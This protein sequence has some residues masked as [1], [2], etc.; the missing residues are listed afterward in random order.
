[1]KNKFWNPLYENSD[2]V[3]IMV[4]MCSHE[5]QTNPYGI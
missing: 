5:P 1:M 2:Y 3:S 4:N